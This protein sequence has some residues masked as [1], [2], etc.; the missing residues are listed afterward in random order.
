MLDITE[1]KGLSKKSKLPWDCMLRPWLSPLSVESQLLSE[2]KGIVLEARVVEIDC[3]VDKEFS[4]GQN[5]VDRTHFG[6]LF[7]TF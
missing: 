6:A 1:P 4:F 2:T 7:R 5:L 3:D